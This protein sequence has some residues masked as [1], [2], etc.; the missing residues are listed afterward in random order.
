MFLSILKILFFTF[1]IP[2]VINPCCVLASMSRAS[3]RNSHI[4]SEIYDQPF[5][6]MIS[7]SQPRILMIQLRL[8]LVVSVR[9]S[10]CTAL[11]QTHTFHFSSSKIL[12]NLMACAMVRP[13]FHV[14]SGTTGETQ[15]YSASTRGSFPL[16]RRSN[17][18][19]LWVKTLSTFDPLLQVVQDEKMHTRPIGSSRTESSSSG[20]PIRGEGAECCDQRKCLCP[21]IR[22]H[23]T[24]D[25][26][27]EPRAERGRLLWTRQGKRT[28]KTSVT[29][30]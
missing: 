2:T 9:T 26:R 8:N 13:R 5:Q 23:K 12:A 29:R 27:R 30:G 21:F 11:N 7:S 22:V 28:S 15:S 25:P 4:G 16:M 19:R 10:C 20:A 1:R 18:C 14:W 6:L 3:H 24:Q 17:V